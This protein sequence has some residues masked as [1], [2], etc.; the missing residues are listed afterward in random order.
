[1][2][3]NLDRWLCATEILDHHH[4][5]VRTQARTFRADQEVE[6]AR[7]AF[8]WVRDRIRHAVDFGVDT[9][10]C[11]ASEVLAVGAGLCY[12]K[13]HLLVAMLRACGL[14]AGLAYQRIR[15][16]ERFVL[17]GLVAVRLPSCGWYRCDPRGN[18]SD[19]D[20]RFMPP[21][22]RLAYQEGPDVVPVPGLFAEPLPEVVRALR[23]SRTLEESLAA[24]PDLERGELAEVVGPL[25][26]S[27][28]RH[29]DGSRK[30][31]RLP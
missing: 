12:A 6:T 29:S 9:V 23:G 15:E 17:H 11:S 24:L 18:S 2:T 3:A 19:L 14:P 8:E 25:V 31:S 7:R 26:R 30:P 20:A 22:E 27:E 10:A 28:P 21:V 4:G 1:M 16:G 13:S 5:E